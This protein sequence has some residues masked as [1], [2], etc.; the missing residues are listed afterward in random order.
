MASP[1]PVPRPGG[2]VV[3]YGSNARESVAASMPQ[4][5]SVM[6]TITACSGPVGVCSRSTLPVSTVTRPPDGIASRALSTRFISV[7]S[8]WPTLTLTRPSRGSS[9]SATWICSPSSGAS[10]RTTPLATA[11]RSSDVATG[12]A[13]RLV[14]S[15]CW[16][17]LRPHTAALR[18]DSA[19][20]RNGSVGSMRLS[21]SSL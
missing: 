16:V 21:I 2:F 12:A 15:M 4:P 18:M 10:V 7:C 5:V 9:S 8:T 20:V 19:P 14:V 3:K 1:R 11:F 6:R 13:A 17:R